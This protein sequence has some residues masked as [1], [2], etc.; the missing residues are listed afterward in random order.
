MPAAPQGD[1]GQAPGRRRGHPMPERRLLRVTNVVV[2][3]QGGRSPRMVSSVSPRSSRRM[4]T[5]RPAPPEPPESGMSWAVGK[6]PHM[7][8][9]PVCSP[10]AEGSRGRREESPHCPV[11]RDSLS[12]LAKPSVRLSPPTPDPVPGV[13]PPETE[14]MRL[15]MV[16]SSALRWQGR[17]LDAS[18][19]WWQ[20][21]E[22][23]FTGPGADKKDVYGC[24]GIMWR[25]GR[26]RSRGSMNGSGHLLSRLLSRCSCTSA[27]FSPL[28]LQPP[29]PPEGTFIGKSCFKITPRPDALPLRGLRTDAQG[30]GWT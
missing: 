12:F 11:A 1:P 17:H 18:S 30:P 25:S 9:P 16:W 8:V 29:A 20:V 6:V 26:A 22:N 4:G 10:G 13:G 27:S 5:P 2:N 14:K 21:T 7:Q 28:T 19:R 23:E 24:P 3:R 15:L